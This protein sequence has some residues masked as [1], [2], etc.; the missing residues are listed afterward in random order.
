MRKNNFLVQNF[1]KKKINFFE[2]FCFLPTY[3][4]D[5]NKCG[6]KIE[7]MIA[8]ISQEKN[9]TKLNIRLNDD[10]VQKIQRASSGGNNLFPNFYTFQN[11]LILF[12]N[13]KA[14]RLQLG[15]PNV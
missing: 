10:K 15:G 9:P 8:S 2:K 7:L 13:K 5:F 12:E 4:F 1:H 3:I 11:L 14:K 6:L